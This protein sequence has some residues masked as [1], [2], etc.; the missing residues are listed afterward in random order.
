MVTETRL[1][2]FF[3]F[4]GLGLFGELRES[5]GRERNDIPVKRLCRDRE[6]S[7][8]KTLKNQLICIPDDF[9]RWGK[10]GKRD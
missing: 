4:F 6:T 8:Y 7:R 10:T 9:L 3:L 1:F 2:F 5:R